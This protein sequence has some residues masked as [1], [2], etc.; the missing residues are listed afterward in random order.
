MIGLLFR[1]AG[2]SEMAP[3]VCFCSFMF[4]QK[5]YVKTKKTVLMPKSNL[6]TTTKSRVK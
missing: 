1:H 3:P 4:N 5:T 2:G 6:V